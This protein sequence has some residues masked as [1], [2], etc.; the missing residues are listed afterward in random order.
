MASKPTAPT[1]LTPNALAP[2][3]P[4]ALAVAL[5]G[6]GAVVIDACLAIDAL[7]GTPPRKALALRFF[8]ACNA[9]AVRLIVPPLF[10]CETDTAVR[11]LLQRGQLPAGTSLAVY[12]ALDALPLTVALAAPELLTVRLRAR[13]IADELQQP[14]VY[15][16]TYAALAEARGCNFWTA[17]KRFANAAKQ[18]RRQP[19]GTTAPALPLVRFVGDYP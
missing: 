18:V 7:L 11:R 5:H 4:D 17:D 2:P 3:A 10:F 14:G 12:A 19:D 16:A 13:Q 1:A 9:G 8:A 6:A 15:D